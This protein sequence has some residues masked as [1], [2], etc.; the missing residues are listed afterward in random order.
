MKMKQNKGRL[1]EKGEHNSLQSPQDETWSKQE[2]AVF[3]TSQI[4]KP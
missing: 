3:G 2:Q 1:C 4:P